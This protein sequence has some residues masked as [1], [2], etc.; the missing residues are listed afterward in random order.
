M[1][2]F[3]L[4]NTIFGIISGIIGLISTWLFHD[5]NFNALFSSNNYTNWYII[6]FIFVCIITF[7]SISLLT[8]ILLYLISNYYNKK[9]QKMH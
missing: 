5:K 6:G 2:N 3:T 8:F 1:S 4:K 9:K 7:S